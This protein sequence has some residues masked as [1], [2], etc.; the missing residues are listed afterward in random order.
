MHFHNHKWDAAKKLA[1]SFMSKDEIKEMNTEQANRMENVGRFRDAELLY[2]RADKADTAIEMYRKQRMF[3]E[4]I[5]LVSVYHPDT[6]KEVQHSLAKQLENEGTLKNAESHY[7]DAGEWLSAVDMYS[8]SDMWEDAI[9]MVKHYGGPTSQKRIAYAWA[10]SLGV[11]GNSNS[12]RQLQKH[13]LLEPAIEYA[14]ETGDF[15]Y[16]FELARSWLPSKLPGIHLKYAMYLEDEERFSEAEAGE[17]DIKSN[18]PT[19]DTTICI[20]ECIPLH[21]ELLLIISSISLF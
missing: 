20:Y 4:V 5:R 21:H 17:C 11:G 2:L 16:A 13:G 8:S 7:V 10:S 3:D 9:R 1:I 6:L 14:I 18:N 15:R 19:N 12:A